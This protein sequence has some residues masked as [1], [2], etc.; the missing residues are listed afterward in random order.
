[1]A[2]R[3]PAGTLRALARNRAALLAVVLLLIISLASV[4]AGAFT[5]HDPL[6]INLAQA[7][8][9]PS[10][11]HLLGTDNLGRDVLA[12]LLYGGRVSLAIVLI[13]TLAA[14]VVV[15]RGVLVAGHYRRRV[16]TPLLAG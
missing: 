12:R 6:A 1:M 7:L 4:F 10:A 16:G 14:L 13:S 5:P 2:S 9:P 11:T 3:W 8:Q 15:V